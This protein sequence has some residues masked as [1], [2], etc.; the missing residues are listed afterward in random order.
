MKIPQTPLSPRALQLHPNKPA[1]YIIAASHEL[2]HLSP[3]AARTLLQRGIRMNPESIDMWREYVRMELGFIE[4]LR[5]R[6]DILG[7][8]LT[9]RAKGKVRKGKGKA[10][11]EAD[12][13]EFIGLAFEG[14]GGAGSGDKSQGDTE[15]TNDD[16]MQIDTE[17]DGLD[18]DEGSTARRQIMQGA[19]VKSVMASAAEGM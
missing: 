7:I 18:G 10:E 6:W 16:L 19:I 3:S 1:L 4:S 9:P 13:S 15:A 5:R 8:S 17:N 14:P 2:D 12:P 11:E